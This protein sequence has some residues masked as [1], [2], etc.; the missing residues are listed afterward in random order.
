MKIVHTESSLGWGGQ[1][2]R[3]AREASLLASAGHDVHVICDSESLLSERLDQYAPTVSLHKVRLKKKRL[4]DLLALLRILKTLHPDLVVC[5]SS[6]D[7]W[8][9]AVARA[10]GSVKFPIVRA[11]HI[12]API[13]SNAGTRWLYRSGCEAIL[14]TGESIRQA[15]IDDKLVTP[16]KVQSIPT[17]INSERFLSVSKSE[18]RKQ[19]GL[20]ASKPLIGIIATLRSWKGHDDLLQA[21][22]IMDQSVQVVIVGDGPRRSHLVSLVQQLGLTNQVIWAGQQQNIEEW[23]AALDVFVLPSYANEGVPQAILQAMASG[24]PIVTCPIGGIPEAIANYSAAWICP[25]CC[26]SD[27]AVAITN[28]L[29]YLKQ[30]PPRN[31]LSRT[32][33]SSDRMLQDCETLYQNTVNEYKKSH[34]AH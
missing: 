11:R 19:L 4:P 1:E 24:L 30:S 28:S 27:L 31:L 8:L 12:S 9:V 29:D 23:F 6:T 25:T 17:G 18:A 3:I 10:L 2:I 33:Y 26:P 16:E 21:V 20:T 13:S 34:L 7:H 14:T 15:M 5:H 22:A 32:P